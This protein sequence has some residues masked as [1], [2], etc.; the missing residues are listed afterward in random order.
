MK[1]F[2]FFGVLL[3]VTG[4][5]HYASINQIQLGMTKAQIEQIVGEMTLEGSS[6]NG[7]NYIC[8][9][10][11]SPDF[12]PFIDKPAPYILTFNSAGFLTD[13]TLDKNVLLLD[14]ARRTRRAIE[15][16]N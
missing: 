13:I 2:L 10:V 3:V 7:N 11:N 1:R 15:L 12:N 8:R 4:C 6:A 5:Q 16:Q 14:E 9:I